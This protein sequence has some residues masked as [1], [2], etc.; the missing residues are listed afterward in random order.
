MLIRQGVFV[1]GSLR[2]TGHRVPALVDLRTLEGVRALVA[3]L[4][5]AATRQMAV[6]DAVP[7]EW[8]MLTTRVFETGERHPDDDVRL[9]TL[10]AVQFGDL[11]NEPA[12]RRRVGQRISELTVLTACVGLVFLTDAWAGPE[13]W[14]SPGEAIAMEEH[15]V[16]VL[17]DARDV[18]LV[19]LEH[20]EI[21]QELS[22]A[23]ARRPDGVAPAPAVLSA[24]RRVPD[25][26]LARGVRGTPL[27]F[28]RQDAR[29]F[30]EQ[31]R[32]LSPAAFMR[33]A[34]QALDR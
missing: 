31:T 1:G 32:R 21:G 14:W 19:S 18:V 4:Q 7:A 11:W 34:Q 5:Q 27:R 28:M 8:W 22:V 33:A 2:A 24:F 17:P 29:R 30:V 15:G 12:G 25:D 13:R 10:R 6:E 16:D 23:E 3:D 20:V 9:V 26:V